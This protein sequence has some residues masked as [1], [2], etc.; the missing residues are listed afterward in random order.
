MIQSDHQGA[1]AVEVSDALAIAIVTAISTL[2][3]A[4]LSFLKRDRDD[5]CDEHGPTD[6]PQ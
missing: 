2:G 6:A 5:R 4:Y 3:G 1:D